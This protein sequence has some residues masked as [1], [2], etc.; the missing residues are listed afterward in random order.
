MP[1]SDF[2]DFTETLIISKVLD[3]FQKNFDTTR[4]NGQT[5]K[6]PV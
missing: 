2:E 3:E 5:S 1:G 6:H 4:R